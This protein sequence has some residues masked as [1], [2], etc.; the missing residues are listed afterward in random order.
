[1]N[2]MNVGAGGRSID[3]WVN[4][5]LEQADGTNVVADLLAPQGLP[6]ADN[7]FDE[8]LMSHVLEHLDKPLFIM[9][10]LHRVAKPGCTLI[11]RVPYGSSDNAWEDPTHVRLY[12]FRSFTYFEQPVYSKNDY[13]YR[14]DWMTT[15]IRLS[16]DK[17]R[18]EGV[19][20]SE[21]SNIIHR[22]RNNV[23]EMEVE[24]QCVKPIRPRLAA[25]ATKHTKLEYLMV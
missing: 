15:R 2:K 3:G 4:L 6:F 19:P 11:V 22:E 23:R 9:E 8:M 24:L 1:M 10:E 5:D 25:L 12:F 7:T 20:D 16:L 14:G 21:F 18:F 13:K 17:R